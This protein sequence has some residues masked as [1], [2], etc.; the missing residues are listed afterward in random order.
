MF[1]HL[2]LDWE[3]LVLGSW[4]LVLHII[5]RRLGYEEFFLERKSHEKY[6]FY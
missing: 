3:G 1:V 5:C 4:S 6:M 2:Q